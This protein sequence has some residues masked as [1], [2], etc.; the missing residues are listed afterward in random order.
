MYVS[1]FSLFANEADKMVLIY[2]DHYTVYVSHHLQAALNMI[3]FLIYGLNLTLAYYH[4]VRI[5]NSNL[6][7]VDLP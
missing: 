5:S 4:F 7:V 6:T 1:A 3:N 2:E